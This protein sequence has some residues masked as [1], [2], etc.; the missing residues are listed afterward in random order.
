MEKGEVGQRRKR[1]M[2]D[3]F[4][5]FSLSPSLSLSLSARFTN[6]SYLCYLSDDRRQSKKKAAAIDIAIF[7]LLPAQQ[8]SKRITFSEAQFL[9]QGTEKM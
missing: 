3:M 7:L 4:Y 1:K 6:F 9:G 5:R 2:N 8:L